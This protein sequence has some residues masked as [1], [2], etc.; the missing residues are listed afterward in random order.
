MA[1]ARR[2]KLPMNQATHTRRAHGDVDQNDL[3]GSL[4]WN[5]DGLV[6]FP[7]TGF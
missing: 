4:D 2:A 1:G 6:A 7:R 5:L 3:R